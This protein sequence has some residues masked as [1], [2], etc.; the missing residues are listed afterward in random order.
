MLYFVLVYGFIVPQIN[1]RSDFI[2]FLIKSRTYFMAFLLIRP[3]Y[4]FVKFGMEVQFKFVIYLAAICLTIYFI[5]LISGLKL[6]PIAMGDRYINSG[7]MRITLWSYGLFD[8]VL[9]LAFIVFLLKIKVKNKKL[10]FY[11]GLLMAF[12]IVLT[13]TRRELLDR[14][15]SLFIVLILV[16]YLLGSH[17]KIQIIKLFLPLAIVIGLLGI[18]FPK[19]IGYVNNEYKS[20]ESLTK[21]GKDMAGNEDYRFAG[22]G[23]VVLMKK[24]IRENLFFGVGFTRYS[25]EDLSN[26][27]DSNNP[28]AGLYAGGEL[29]YLGSIGKMGIFGLLMFLPVYIL[30]LNMSLKLYRIIKNNDI[31]IFIRNNYYELIFSVFALT[32]TINKFTFTLYNIFVETNNSS[33][34]FIFIVIVSILIACYNS[35]NKALEQQKVVLQNNPVK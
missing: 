23:D 9:N 27:R 26:L 22:T 18:T 35:F 17:R 20:V 7:I 25:L 8:W 5:S 2:T 24:L 28:L 3:I 4:F 30:I 11:S 12:T 10:L 1:G 13:L 6:I 19:Y 15:F 33:S 32:F 34:F 16:K 31:N 14:V 21:T 29:P